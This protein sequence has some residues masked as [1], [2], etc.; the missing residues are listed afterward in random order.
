MVNN[1]YIPKPVPVALNP[2][3]ELMKT[4]NFTSDG[5]KALG[6]FVLDVLSGAEKQS[7]YAECKKYGT[8]MGH[9]PRSGLEAVFWIPFASVFILLILA[10]LSHQKSEQTYMHGKHHPEEAT[11][12]KLK[13]RRWRIYSVLGTTIAATLVFGCVVFEALAGCALTYCLKH[14]LIFFYW[15]MWTLTQVGSFIA[16]VGVTVHQWACLGEHSTPPWN[17][18]L[19]TPI[20]VITGVA[21]I[22]GSWVAK[23]LKKWTCLEKPVSSARSTYNSDE[24]GR[25]LLIAHKMDGG[26]IMEYPSG[27]Q[28]RLEVDGEK[29]LGTNEYGGQ[30]IEYP[31][32]SLSPATEQLLT[33]IVTAQELPV[34]SSNTT[35]AL[36]SSSAL[37]TS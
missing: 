27:W 35:L 3:V 16:I 12:L 15:G 21:H 22:A 28:G 11:E 4:S 26:V 8:F 25:P 14:K 2:E 6:A 7:G 29:L 24:Q 13:Q 34:S 30:I 33:K 18:A 31:P 20:L 19:G 1:D 36:P 5:V 9:L 10:A 37:L 32:A 17:V 23:K